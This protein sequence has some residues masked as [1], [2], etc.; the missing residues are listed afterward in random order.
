M[1]ARKE[2]CAMLKATTMVEEGSSAA[3]AG[4]A[5]N[6]F[7]TGPCLYILM[8]IVYQITKC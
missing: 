1:M 7:H 3:A 2:L 6:N 4:V 5:A 8:H